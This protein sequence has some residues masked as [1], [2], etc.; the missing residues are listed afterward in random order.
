MVRSCNQLTGSATQLFW[1]GAGKD[2]VKTETDPFSLTCWKNELAIQI[3]RGG[4]AREEFSSG[5]NISRAQ[6][7]Y[8]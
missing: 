5:R 4:E 6:P 7:L 8:L 3:R 1:Q 2:E